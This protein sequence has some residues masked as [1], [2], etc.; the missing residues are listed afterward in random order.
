MI[1]YAENLRNTSP[2]T[3]TIIIKTKDEKHKKI[4]SSDLN[5]S[6]NFQLIIANL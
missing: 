4:L 3:V 1:L 5:K 2:N 6:E